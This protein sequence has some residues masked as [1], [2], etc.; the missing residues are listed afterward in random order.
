MQ[1]PIGTLPNQ[2]VWL[3]DPNG[4]TMRCVGTQR[5]C[6]SYIA[7]DHAAFIDADR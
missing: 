7:P 2:G 3:P 1:F 6:G 5:E 4:T